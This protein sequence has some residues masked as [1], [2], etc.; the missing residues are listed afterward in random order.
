MLE[1]S[2]LK[3]G[4]SFRPPHTHM[5]TLCLSLS[6]DGCVFLDNKHLIELSLDNDSLVCS[7]ENMTADYYY[8]LRQ[9]RDRMI[10]HTTVE[11]CIISLLHRTV[12]WTAL[13]SMFS[14]SYTMMIVSSGCN[15]QNKPTITRFHGQV[16]L[17][18]YILVYAFIG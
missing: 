16:I 2:W 11:H 15:N 8:S 6:L 7:T 9:T 5:H 4:L 12:I 3:T 18:W 1:T 17:S 13:G 10:I 14:I